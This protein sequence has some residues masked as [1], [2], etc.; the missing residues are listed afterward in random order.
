MVGCHALATSLTHIQT[1]C[2]VSSLHTAEATAKAL[3][4]V[5]HDSYVRGITEISM[6]I[7]NR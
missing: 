3:Q 4:Q 2:G 7:R 1:L 6:L 5:S